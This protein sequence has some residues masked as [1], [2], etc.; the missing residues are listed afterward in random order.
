MHVEFYD[1]GRPGAEPVAACDIPAVPR[2]GDLVELPEVM[3]GVVKAVEWRLF[4]D[5]VNGVR[6]TLKRQP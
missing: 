6:V 5:E 2:V 1:A 3:V 4:V